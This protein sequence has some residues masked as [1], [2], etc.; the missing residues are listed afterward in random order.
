MSTLF[1]PT[2][3]RILHVLSDGRGHTRA[4][5][6]AV[7]EDDQ[8]GPKAVAMHVTRIRVKLRPRGESISNEKDS[9]GWV[10]RLVRYISYR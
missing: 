8:A 9:A 4:E 10:Y 7:L 5:L 6:E 3:Q 1:T 2:E